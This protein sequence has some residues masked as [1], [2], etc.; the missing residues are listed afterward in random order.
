MMGKLESSYFFRIQK[1][2][3]LKQRWVMHIAVLNEI[4]FI[5]KKSQFLVHVTRNAESCIISFVLHISW[6]TNNY[7]VSHV[8]L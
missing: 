3:K 8:D 6:A 4:E 7:P 1:P 5:S 2:N